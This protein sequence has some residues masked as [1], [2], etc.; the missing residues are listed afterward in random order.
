MANVLALKEDDLKTMLAAN[1]HIG[2]KNCD[3]NMQRYIWKKRR[4]GVSLIN[5]GKTWEKLTLAARVIVA[6]ENPSDVV[7]ISARPYG[8][9]AVLKFGQYTGATSVAGRYTPGALTNQIQ[10]KFTEPRLLIVTDPRI[11][12]QPVKEASYANIPVIAFCDTDS[13][14]THV[15]IAIPANNRGKHSIALLYYLLAREVLYMRARL[16]RAEKWNVMVDLFMYRDP[17]EVEKQQAAQEAITGAAA[18]GDD[19]AYGSAAFSGD[20]DYE[21]EQT[22]EEPKAEWTGAAESTEQYDEQ[23]A[24]LT[25][26]EWNTT[27]R[28]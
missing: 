8:Q 14:T 4:D 18:T 6:I 2:T 7:A 1:V 3:P 17:E 15:D 25:T 10:A 27:Q 5:I 26:D 21:A 19:A 23:G 28:W 24:Q 20:A 16:S 12:H 22:T 11:D 9:R 13:P